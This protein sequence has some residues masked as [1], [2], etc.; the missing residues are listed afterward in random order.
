M[1]KFFIVIVV[2]SGVYLLKTHWTVYSKY[3]QFTVHKS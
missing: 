2:V 3:V 1:E